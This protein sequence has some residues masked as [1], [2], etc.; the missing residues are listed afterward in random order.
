MA[1]QNIDIADLGPDELMKL[2]ELL[3]IG[4]LAPEIF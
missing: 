2:Q 3:Q 1:L 4:H